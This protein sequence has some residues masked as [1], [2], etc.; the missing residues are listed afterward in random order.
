MKVFLI[1]LGCDKNLCD[2]EVMLGLLTGAGYEI[3]DCEAEADIIIVN[4]CSFIGDS[5]EES[6]NAIIDAGTYKTS[7]RCKALIV[8]GCLSQRFADEIREQLPE[9]DGMLGTTSYADIVELISQIM[10]AGEESTAPACIFHS[11][12]AP[13]RGDL[14]RILSTGGHYAYMKIA[15]GCGKCCTYC[16]IPSIRGSFRSVPMEQLIEQASRLAAGG[17]KELI[18]VAQETTLYGIDLYGRKALPELVSRLAE[19]EDLEWIRLLYCYPEEITDEMQEM[20]A[21]CDKLVKY[22]DIPIQSGSNAILTRMGRLTSREDILALAARLRDKCPE[23]ALRT[24]II[25]GFPGESK[26][27]HEQTLDMVRRVGFDRLGVFT[28]SREEGTPAYDM[29]GQIDEEVKAARRDEIMLLQQEISLEKSR[30]FIGRRLQCFIE[31]KV[32]DEDV[33]V[34]RTYR[35][36]PD[37]DGYIFINCDYELMSGDIVTA[38]VT[39]ASEYDLIG[40]VIDDDTQ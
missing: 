21:S 9:V 32:A 39:D 37:V 38:L 40:E 20:F 2:S 17:V 15:E 5:Q 22:L 7:G 6:I 30:G 13:E 11:I 28:Y 3:T 33:Y 24:S 29:E 19:I 1:S 23:I 34:A 8:T 36:A 31:G 10:Q 18:L 4:T 35:D 14:P 26:E 12:N 27:D 16:A 25:T